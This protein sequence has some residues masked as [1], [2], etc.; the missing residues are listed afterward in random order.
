[1]IVSAKIVKVL[2][3]QPRVRQQLERDEWIEVT[4]GEW[5][6]EV[7]A[8]RNQTLTVEE[9]GVLF[10]PK[11]HPRDRE[12]KWADVLGRLTKGAALKFDGGSIR[13]TTG[14]TGRYQIKPTGQRKRTLSDV[15]SAS[16]AAAETF[17]RSPESVK[18]PGPGQKYG[19]GP[20]YYSPEVA[21]INGWQDAQDYLKKLGLP[22]TRFKPVT[23]TN[24]DQVSVDYYRQVAQA[25]TDMT[26]KHP[27]LLRGHEKLS[28]P[29][30]GI[31]WQDNY[32]DG[33]SADRGAWGVTGNPA[34]DFLPADP[35]ESNVVGLT[36]DGPVD[37]I[38]D[39]H[40]SMAADGRAGYAGLIPYGRVI[41]ELG[42]ATA[43]ASGWVFDATTQTYGENWDGKPRHYDID[44]NGDLLQQSDLTPDVLHGFTPYGAQ[45]PNE[46]IA[47]VYAALNTWPADKNDVTPE[48]Y[49]KLKRFR[50]D[51]NA[52]S[53][54]D[55]V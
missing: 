10:D 47:E 45:N 42:H 39:M 26:Q 3:E 37:D 44:A 43:A 2:A 53:G 19:I 17:P 34:E 21:R 46:A 35:G 24:T 11:L 33:F 4:P 1:M 9:A 7:S 25:V 49:E 13:R 29:L 48:V 36:N 15:K 31:G 20:D 14:S 16:R 18:V 27:V 50:A 30:T 41:H 5:A 32:V 12:G 38:E 6:A 28:A 22:D 23:N 40:D 54:V 51:V 52:T 8:A 55:A